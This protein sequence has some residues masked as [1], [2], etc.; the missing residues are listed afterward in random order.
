M[1][2]AKNKAAQMIMN[3]TSLSAFFLRPGRVNWIAPS[4][5]SKFHFLASVIWNFTNGN[6]PC[7][8]PLFRA[9]H[10]YCSTQ[11]SQVT[12]FLPTIVGPLIL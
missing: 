10:R 7:L 4:K 9:L 6:W 8:E 5:E 2:A 11:I 3:Q 12:P 1:F